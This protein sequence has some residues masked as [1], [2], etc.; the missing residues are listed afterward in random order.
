MPGDGGL[1]LRALMAAL[2]ADLPLGLEV[3]LAGRFPAMQPSDRLGALV[4]ASRAYLGRGVS[5]PHREE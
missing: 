3:P 1:D 2:P 5:L 4:R